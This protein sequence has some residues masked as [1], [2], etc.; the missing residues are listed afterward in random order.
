MVTLN[1]AKERVSDA[2]SNM[3]TTEKVIYVAVFL[4]IAIYIWRKYS[5]YKRE[6]PFFYKNG[7]DAKK[8]EVIQ[9]RVFIRN[10]DRVQFTYHMFLYIAEWDYNIFWF[11]PIIMK[12]SSLNQFCPLMYFEPVV[13]NLVVVMSSEDGL[14]NTIYI[15]DFPIK[16]W[17]HV[18][19]VADDISVEIYIN[20]LLAETKNLTSPPKQNDGNLQVSP[21][22]GFSGFIS[23]LAYRHIALSSR[24][25]FE[26]SRRPIFDFSMFAI[27]LQN[28]NI[29]GRT[30][31]KPNETDLDGVPHESLSVF[32][33]I[34][35]SLNPLQSAGNNIFTS[36]SKRMGS[37]F[38]E[39]GN[40]MT[41]S[42]DSCPTESDAPLCPVGTLACESNQKYCYYPDRDIMVSTYMVQE[43]DY[44]PSKQ[45]GNSNGNLPFT[46]SGVPVWKR[47]QGKDTAN[48]SNIK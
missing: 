19:V 42:G 24:E 23:K 16:R 3:S 36:M 27:S 15:K 25:I 29:C 18:A 6:N 41:T 33:S 39:L 43:D 47:Q 22:G 20:G 14:N 2:V 12:S 45:I 37:A 26:L 48:C 35:N 46:I 8:P 9:D 7:K 13:N 38:S 40:Q 34:P 4:F 31:K 17:T 21:M 5:Q 30:Y 44:C 32:G 10:R 1:D 28:L 11:K